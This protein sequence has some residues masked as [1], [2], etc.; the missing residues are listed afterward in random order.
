MKPY[1]E[2]N[3]EGIQEMSDVCDQLEIAQRNARELEQASVRVRICQD[4]RAGTEI[5]SEC[6]AMYATM[7]SDLQTLSE[8]NCGGFGMGLGGQTLPN[9]DASLAAKDSSAPGQVTISLLLA[10]YVGAMTCLFSL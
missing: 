4:D 6:S 3:A 7:T 9:C 2:S 5:V 1:F 8:M 10:L